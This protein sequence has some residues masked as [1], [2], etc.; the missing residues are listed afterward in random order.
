M[1]VM[2]GFVATKLIREKEAANNRAPLPIIAIT[3]NVMP[4]VQQQCNDAGMD[5]Y[6]RY[7][8]YYFIVIIVFNCFIIS[9]PV[10]MSQLVQVFNDL[11]ILK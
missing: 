10:Q 8:L 7:L 4:D 6:I 11:A 2:D 1:P 3:A 5:G 9:K